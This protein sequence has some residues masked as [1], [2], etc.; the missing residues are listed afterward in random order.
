MI[1][2]ISSDAEKPTGVVLMTDGVDVF[3]GY[4]DKTSGWVSCYGEDEY[5]EITHFAVINLPEVN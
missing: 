3:L 2:W 4:Y 1:N 5:G